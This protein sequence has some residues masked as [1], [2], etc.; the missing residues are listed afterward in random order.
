MPK[1][2]KPMD[3]GSEENFTKGSGEAMEPVSN[4]STGNTTVSE[5][6]ILARKSAALSRMGLA[7]K[8][9]VARTSLI[10]IEDGDVAP[11]SSTI[12]RLAMALGVNAGWLLHGIE[13]PRG[14]LPPMAPEG[15]AMQAID[16]VFMSLVGNRREFEVRLNERRSLGVKPSARYVV[17]MIL[18]KLNEQGIE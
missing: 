11:H 3:I 5:R 8:S 10:R 6:L 4:M 13:G 12:Q 17:E 7:K 2:I 16:N 14:S 9:G 1:Q 18:E 15:T